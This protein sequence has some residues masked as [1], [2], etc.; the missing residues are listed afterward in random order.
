MR[1][2]ELSVSGVEIEVKIN[3]PLIA[4]SVND[5]GCTFT[6]SEDWDPLTKVAVF[7]GGN[8]SRSVILDSSTVELPWET[9]QMPKVAYLIGVYGLDAGQLVRQTTPLLV[10]YV[11]C[12]TGTSAQTAAAPSPSLQQ[13]L[14]TATAQAV[15]AAAEAVEQASI[16]LRD[17]DGT[18][19]LSDDGRYKQMSGDGSAIPN[20]L[21]NPH[22]LR[23][24]GAVTA[25]YDGSEEIEIEIPTG[26]SGSSGVGIQS[27]EQTVTSEESCGVNIVTVTMTDGTTDTFEVRNG[28]QG[29]KGADGTGVTILGSF[30][31]E[32]SLIAA[33][34]TGN[35][36][37]SYLVAGFLYVWS[38]STNSWSNVGNIQ[39]PKGET[40]AQGPKGDT[41]AAGATG[42]QGPKGNTGSA[43]IYVRDPETE[44]VDQALANADAV[45]ATVFID[46]EE[47]DDSEC[48]TAS[49]L[50]DYLKS[51]EVYI[52]RDGGYIAGV[53]TAA[54]AV[55]SVPITFKKPFS[56]KPLITPVFYSGSAA[57]GF[58][59]CVLSVINIT[60][61]GCTINVYNGDSAGRSPGIIWDAK[62]W[63]ELG[64]DM[65]A[66]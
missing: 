3:Q 21:P 24:K 27:I 20:A 5:V 23:F 42:P 10:G 62:W 39:G 31:T 22:S 9:L 48:V 58:G 65:Y 13:Q 19:F 38:A 43:G 11:R 29:E 37:E 30:D 56:G 15:R 66:Q 57:A 54:G 36:G 7:T 28:K 1:I 12:G 47:T 49:N 55:T 59:K 52:E 2:I 8:E 14:I 41:G 46:P 25:E 33:H 18:R 6:F 61:T 63:S 40:G 16:L 26:G 64:E 4:G 45:G 17:G 35:I 60:A 50:D 51:A 53:T 34:P 44:T 32:D